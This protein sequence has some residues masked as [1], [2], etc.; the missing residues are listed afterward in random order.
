MST[1]KFL[2]SWGMVLAYI[3]FN[4][5]GALIIK[6]K[7][8]EMGT[9]QLGSFRFVIKYF[10]ELIKSPLIICGIFSIF[11]SAFVWMVALS[12]L[13]ISIAYP[14]AVG[15]NFIVVVTV[16]LIFFKEHLSAEKIIG[17]VLIF[18]SVFLISR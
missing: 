11:I 2:L 3:V 18:I 13:Q 9:I 7:I 8:N 4:S 15:L 17:I 5:F 6:Y 12:R 10:Y 1:S 14:V 16:A